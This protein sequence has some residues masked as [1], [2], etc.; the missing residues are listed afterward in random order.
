MKKPLLTVGC[1]EIKKLKIIA[2][3]LGM[4]STALYLM[5]SKGI[6]NRADYAIFSDPGAELPDTYQLLKDLQ[7]WQKR[8][9]G[10]EIIVTKSDLYNDILSDDIKKRDASIPAHVRNLED[11]GGMLKRQC[12]SH[13]KIEPV[14]KE[15]RKLYK[16]KPKQHMLPTEIWLGIST[17]EI[18]RA[19]TSR[20]YNVQ[21]IYPLIDFNYDRSDCKKFLSDNGFYNVKKSSCVFCPYKSNRDWK[22]IKTQYPKEWK[23]VIKIDA[24]IRKG[25]PIKAEAFLHRSLRPINEVYLQENQEELFMCEEGY[26]GL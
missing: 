22:E 6:I 15:I 19:K 1:K 9:N 16:L 13:Y 25:L 17:D 4:Q 5:S 10:I 8:N 23:K 26:C 24:K 11:Q 20:Q 14:Y 3:G 21:N 7:I 12:T 2:L 18:Q